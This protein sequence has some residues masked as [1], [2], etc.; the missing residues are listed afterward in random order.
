MT[1][2]KPAAAGQVSRTPRPKAQANP[3]PPPEA[4][5]NPT[6][7]PEAQANRTL[8]IAAVV[9]LVEAVGML[10]ATGFSASATI[11]GKSY[12]TGSGIALT[13][14]AFGTALAFAA[15]ARGIAR[16]NLWSRTP[17]LLTQ[18]FAVGAGIYLMDGHR[19][20]WGIPTLI[21]AGAG[22]VT[23]LAPESFKA[24]NRSPADQ[25]SV[26]KPSRS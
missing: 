4:Q 18:L 23:L 25:S 22:F 9:Q 14:I 11:G 6:P 13:L 17:A 19:L 21:L 8:R 20:E 5:A 2:G 24:L 10:V 3:T 15:I 7:P 26:V 1:N 12:Q 16:A